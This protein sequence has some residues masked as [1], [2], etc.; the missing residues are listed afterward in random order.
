MH[1]TFSYYS[2]LALIRLK[3]L[4]KIFSKLP[5][6]YL[7]FRSYDVYKPKKGYFKT[8]K[9]DFF[10]ILKTTITQLNTHL[11]TDKLLLYFHGGAFVSGP[12]QYHWDA[13]ATIAKNTKHTIWVCNYPKA[14]EYKIDEISANVDQIYQTALTKF[15]SENIILLG[16]S[17]G[18]TLILALTQRLINKQKTPSKMVLISPLLD[19]SLKNTKIDEIDKK[20]PMLAKIGLLSALKMCSDNTN[21]VRISPINGQFKFFP[22]TYLFLAENDITFPDQLEFVSK[23]EH[24]KIDFIQIIGKGMPHIW[25]LLPIMKASKVALN[26]LITII[27][28]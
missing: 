25:P 15:K 23:L 12:A 28:E 9:I 11:E 18:G 17:A 3:G 16:D 20:D 8:A 26:Q 24:E 2:L 4:K 1:K 22:K 21:D 19:A 27:N 5:L 13:I 7:K 6:N 10:S 14:P